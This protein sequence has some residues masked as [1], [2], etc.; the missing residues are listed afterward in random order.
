MADQV[1]TI[2]CGVLWGA[3]IRARNHALASAQTS[4]PGIAGEAISAIILAAATSEAF[5]NEWI[6]WVGFHTAQLPFPAPQSVVAVADTLGPLVEE[7]AQLELKFKLAYFLLSG[8]VLD[9]GAQ[10]YQDF[11]KLIQL[12]NDLVHLKLERYDHDAQKLKGYLIDLQNRGIA[13]QPRSSA[14]GFSWIDLIQT[15][16]MANWACDSVKNM[17]RAIADVCPKMY[18]AINLDFIFTWLSD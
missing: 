6:E 2:S 13:A 12:R 5:I 11:R 8:K 9:Q 4:P 14:A 10:P 7:R 1:C 17:C 3:A 16:E 15:P 18:G